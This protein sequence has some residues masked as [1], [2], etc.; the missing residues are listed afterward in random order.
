ME[1]KPTLTGIQWRKSSYSGDQGGNCV[2]VAELTSAVAVRDS[3]NP[4]GPAL[5]LTPATFT[6]FIDWAATTAN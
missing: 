2:E 6:T 3:K 1:S 5:A 4:A